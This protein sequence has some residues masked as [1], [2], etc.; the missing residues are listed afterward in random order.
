MYESNRLECYI[1][2]SWKALS[3]EEHSSLLGKFKSHERNEVLRIRLQGLYSQHFIFF[4]THKW[5]L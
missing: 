4:V 5:T 1:T 3:E 2:K